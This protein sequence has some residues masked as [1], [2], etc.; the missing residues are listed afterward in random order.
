MLYML[1]RMIMGAYCFCIGGGFKGDGKPFSLQSLCWNSFYFYKI[2][3]TI[4]SQ[5][6]ASKSVSESR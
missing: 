2:G 6:L 1:I 3:L 4:E 5:S